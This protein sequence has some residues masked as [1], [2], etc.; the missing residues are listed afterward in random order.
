MNKDLKKI[1]LLQFVKAF[2]KKEYPLILSKKFSKKI[3]SQINQINKETTYT[4]RPFL[5]NTLRIASAVTFA[6]VT[7]FLLQSFT[8]NDI[9]YS[10]STI[11]NPSII[12]SKNVINRPDECERNQNQEIKSDTINCK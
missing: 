12:P 10:K 7:L 6:V 4:I 1:E 5:Q 2:L 11:S 8:T 3:M 9:E